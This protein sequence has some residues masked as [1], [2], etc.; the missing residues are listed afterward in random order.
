M[1]SVG[2][3]EFSSLAS[4]ILGKKASRNALALS[5]LLVTSSSPIF[6]VGMFEYW[7]YSYIYI[8]AFYRW[9]SLALSR[10]SF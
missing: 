10:N 4:A 6:S 3:I 9:P 1:S 2:A 5:S 7:S 8:A